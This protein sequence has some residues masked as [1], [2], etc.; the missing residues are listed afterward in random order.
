MSEPRCYP[1]AS[2]WWR[3]TP[4]VRPTAAV[5]SLDAQPPEHLGEPLARD[6]QLARGARALPAGAR[7]RGA[8][9]A[10]LELLARR[11]EAWRR[12]LRAPR[13]TLLRA[14]CAGVIRPRRGAC[15]ASDAIAFCSSRTL[16]GQS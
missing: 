5:S 9:V 15:T 2:P 8:D 16:P 12:S 10:A 1:A 11:L 3:G 4:S 6:A 14:A 7:E 13:A